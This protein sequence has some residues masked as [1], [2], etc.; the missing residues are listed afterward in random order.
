[1]WGPRL[2]AGLD[3]LKKRLFLMYEVIVEQQFSAAH[4]LK[5]YPGKCANVH[6][7]NYRVQITVEGATLDSLGMVIEFEVI[8]QA[9]KPWIDRFD[10]ALLNEIPPFDALNPSAENLAKFFY[11]ETA[12]AIGESTAR[13]SYV[14][15][16]ETEKCSAAYRPK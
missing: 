14:R 16:F 4:Y 10:H 6:G 8:K 13:V 5:D 11:D 3:I 2:E 12:R 9:L 15:V 7:H 1:M